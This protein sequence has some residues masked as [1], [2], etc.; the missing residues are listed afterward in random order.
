MVLEHIMQRN[1]GDLMDDSR[2]SNNKLNHT[3]YV[4]IS[5]L[6]S[7]SQRAQMKGGDP[8]HAP[9]SNSVLAK[10]QPMNSKSL[11]NLS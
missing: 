10:Q 6:F 2:Q 4:H 1:N 8:S 11:K 7:P 5:D 3:D 9:Q